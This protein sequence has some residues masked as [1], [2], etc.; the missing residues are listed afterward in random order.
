MAD[1]GYCVSPFLC[2]C[3]VGVSSEQSELAGFIMYKAIFLHSQSSVYT[4][5]GKLVNVHSSGFM[6]FL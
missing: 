3:Q 1:T 4:S 6:P 2:C 5:E